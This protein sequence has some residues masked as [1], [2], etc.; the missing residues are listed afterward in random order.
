MPELIN[1]QGY[2][3][4]RGDR[5]LDGYTIE[6]AIGR[7]GFGEVYYALS[8]SGRE[9]AIKVVQSYEP[10]ELRGVSQCM[11]LKSPHLVSI[12][13]IKHNEANRP[14]VIMEYVAG[15]S[16]RELLDDSPS[17]L[18]EQKAALEGS[19]A[20]CDSETLQGKFDEFKAHLEDF[21]GLEMSGSVGEARGLDR[22]HP[23]QREG[24]LRLDQPIPPD[25]DLP[26]PGAKTGQ[27]RLD[28]LQ[29]VPPGLGVSGL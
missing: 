6:R 21:D 3:F 9:V 10:I 2:T 8:D 26:K 11:N 14:F 12:F 18:G 29:G 23:V 22:V 15:P 24:T 19:L 13:D 17:G 7:G 27:W 28:Q 4:K 20:E 25:P 5:P 16:L 1:M